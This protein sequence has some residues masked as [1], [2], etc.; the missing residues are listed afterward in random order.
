MCAHFSAQ[1]GHLSSHTFIYYLDFSQWI[2]MTFIVRI[3]IF[4]FCCSLSNDTNGQLCK[5]CHRSPTIRIA[6]KGIGHYYITQ[7]LL[8]KVYIMYTSGHSTRKSNA[9]LWESYFVA[10]QLADS[11]N[12][13]SSS[14]ETICFHPGSSLP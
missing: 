8:H 12:P 7:H 10:R 6:V 5:L 2:H 14:L 1:W 13:F 3:Q 4:S 11:Q 9:L